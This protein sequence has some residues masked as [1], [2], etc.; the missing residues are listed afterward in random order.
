MVELA[1]QFSRPYLLVCCIVLS[2]VAALDA[3]GHGISPKHHRMLLPIL[4]AKVNDRARL[5]ERSPSGQCEAFK[6]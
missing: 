1:H 4:L 6:L 2:F 3:L 5:Q